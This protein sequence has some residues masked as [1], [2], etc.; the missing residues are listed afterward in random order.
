MKTRYITTSCSHIPMP[1]FNPKFFESRWKG[2]DWVRA[3]HRCHYKN[4]TSR[5]RK[6]TAL[7]DLYT[8]LYEWKK[9]KKNERQSE[10]AQTKKVPHIP[11][12][13]INIFGP[14]TREI[15]HKILLYSSEKP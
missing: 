3:N 13:T 1:D 10:D 7:M 4:G 15:L 2:L 11:T 6:H 9:A 5:H 8:E 14:A 12:E